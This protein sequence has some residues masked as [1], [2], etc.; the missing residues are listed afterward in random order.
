MWLLFNTFHVQMK[1]GVPR[2]ELISKKTTFE[3]A[4]FAFTLSFIASE[5]I[6]Q[7]KLLITKTEVL[8]S[9]G[10]NRILGLP[11]QTKMLYELG[12]LLNV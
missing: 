5:L 4:S 3:F 6:F 11:C 10:L 9:T 2:S 7:L 8:N 1:V 12:V